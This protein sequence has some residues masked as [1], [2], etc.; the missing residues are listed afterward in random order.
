M[1]K[2]RAWWALGFLVL[3]QFMIVLDV[4]ILNIALP[5]IQRE[6]SLGETAL[7]SIVTAYT[8][9]FGGFLLLGG[10]A[11]DIFGRRR[12]FLAGLTGFTLVSLVIGVAD[13]ESLLIPLRAVQGFCAAFMSPS[14]LSL[15][16]TLFDTPALRARALSIWGAV[17]AGGATAGLLIGGVLT[18]YLSWR[19]NFFVNVPV[20]IAVLVAGWQLLPAH[21]QEE[22]RKSLDIS[23]AVLITAG[24]MT[25]VYALSH[26]H[27]WGWTALPTLA[28]LALAA[29]LIMGFIVNE[30]KVAHPLV[31]FSIFRVGN[32]AA[33]DI[34]QLPITGSLF[35][36]F[37]F[38]SLYVQNLLGYGPL[39]AGLAFLPT[40]LVVG[41]T[42]VLAPRVIARIGHKT[43]LILGPLII[44]GGLF[45]LAHVPLAGSYIFDILPGILMTSVGMGLTFVSISV[46]ATSGVPGHESGLASGLLTT[47]QQIGGSLG[48]AVLASIAGTHT[49]LSLSAGVET[50]QA[51]LD[52]FH[53]AF[54]TGLFFALAAACVALLAIRPMSRTGA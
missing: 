17:S 36:M 10:R 35:A 49:G 30:R 54:Y 2:E 24:L 26:A 14:A 46:A 4:S 52:G 8:L 9:A 40:T 33:A 53:A 50:S 39:R 6:F 18:Q 37:F 5:S 43:A 48:L 44:A 22:K 29:L 31:P 34:M 47:A 20:G 16:L 19:W 13:S 25:I 21:I 41:I 45:N 15:I 32:I 42:A 7:Q 27:T 28:T 3:A 11:A 23:G 51:L 38:M 12:V 1:N